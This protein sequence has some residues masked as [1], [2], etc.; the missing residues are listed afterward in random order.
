M[1]AHLNA[2]KAGLGFGYLFCFL[3][4]SDPK[5]VRLPKSPNDK[6]ITAWVVTHPDLAST[7]RVRVCARF[8][9]DEIWKKVNKITSSI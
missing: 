2:V 4:D 7:E 9:A 8:L 3:A 1:L 5:L 6:A